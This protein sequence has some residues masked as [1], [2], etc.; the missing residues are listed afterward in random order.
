MSAT[1]GQFVPVIDRNRC[2]GKGP[3]AAAC[4]H[5][6]LALGVLERDARRQLSFA[7]RIKGFAHGYR[8]ALIVAADACEACG[9]CVRVCPE[10]AIKLKRV[11]AAGSRNHLN[12]PA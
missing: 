7:G 6:V 5:D 3:C 11:D 9:A 8:Q 2:E 4:P 12:Q 10:G 1:G